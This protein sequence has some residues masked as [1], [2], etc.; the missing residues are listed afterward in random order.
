MEL[1]GIEPL[2]P[3]LQSRC[4]SQLSYSPG[5]LNSSGVNGGL[6][7]VSAPSDRGRRDQPGQ[8][9]REPRIISDTMIASAPADATRKTMVDML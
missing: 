2:T 5:V 3:C 9:W 6:V 1:R 4:S 8:F 7:R